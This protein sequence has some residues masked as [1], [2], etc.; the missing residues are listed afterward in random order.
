MLMA[1]EVDLGCLKIRLEI[2]TG[3]HRDGKIV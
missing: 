1:G 3:G 2:L